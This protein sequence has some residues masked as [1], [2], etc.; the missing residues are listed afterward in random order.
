M[1]YAPGTRSRSVHTVCKAKQ[2]R[3]TLSLSWATMVGGLLTPNEIHGLSPF[4]QETKHSPF[5]SQT[6]SHRPIQC[7]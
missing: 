1:Q 5:R 7:R 6:A 4:P 2:S 3:A